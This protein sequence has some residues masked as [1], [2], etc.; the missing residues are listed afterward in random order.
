MTRSSAFAH[1]S[2]RFSARGRAAGTIAGLALALGLA[3]CS[4]VLWAQTTT[5]WIGTDGTWSSSSNWSNGTPSG[6]NPYP[7]FDGQGVSAITVSTGI[8][9]IGTF[10]A[11]SYTLT[12][13]SIP[14]LSSAGITISAGTQTF[15]GSN[16]TIGQSQTWNVATGAA[17]NASNNITGSSA[18][19]LGGGG[20]FDLSGNLNISNNLT[21]SGTGTAILRGSANTHSANIIV[22]AGTLLINGT[23]SSTSNAVTVNGGT[24]GGTGT[25]NKA[26]TI[27]S[28]GT[29]AP[30][31]GPGVLTFGGALTLASGSTTA[32]ELNGTTRGTGY[33]GLDIAGLTTYGGTLALTFGSTF[34]NGT[35]LDPFNLG[36]TPA[37]SFDFLTGSGSYAGSFA[38]NGGGTWTMTSGG[39][40][41]T[42]TESTGDLVFSVSLIPEPM[43]CA[44]LVG[45]A[46]LA[47]A[48]WRRGGK[49]DQA[50]D[51]GEPDLPA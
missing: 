14:K 7:V 38:N 6:S 23:F 50:P 35:T 47:L 15:N 36:V 13:S 31:A 12:F 29:L 17:L 2:N 48:A 49:R 24:L 1:A 28:G 22:N 25:L 8:S 45:A 26:T 27:N 39:Q 10:T 44:A 34:A 16:L 21:M 20:N 30:G 18:L 42:F 19:T 37:G 11:G 9:R 32:L 5:T 3:I 40:L 33:D 43:T 46:A 41:L 4:P 51:D